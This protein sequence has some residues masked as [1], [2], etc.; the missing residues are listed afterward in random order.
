MADA[1]S[2]T[3]KLARHDDLT[4]EIGTNPTEYL[5]VSRSTTREASPVWDCML[6]PGGN[7][8]E[9]LKTTI[10]LPDDD[11]TAFAIVLRICHL[12]FD[13]LPEQVSIDIMVALAT[14]SD[15]Y[16]GIKTIR[17]FVYKWFSL[18]DPQDI[19]D[20]YDKYFVVALAFEFG[21][22]PDSKWTN[23]VL[24]HV[25]HLSTPSSDGAYCTEEK[26]KEYAKKGKHI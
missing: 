14:L 8:L 20:T 15:K 24:T 25:L 21:S 18:S 26:L 19:E 12:D 5:M 16:D 4:F 2:S 3:T 11:A 17:P 9:S 13:S 7:F 10:S 1:A 23:T 22:A 6:D